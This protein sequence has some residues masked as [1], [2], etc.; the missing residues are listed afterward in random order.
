MV[1]VWRKITLKGRR[2]QG[3]MRVILL[4]PWNQL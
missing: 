1:S 4:T 3:A 2:E